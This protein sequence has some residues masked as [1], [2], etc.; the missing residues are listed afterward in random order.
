MRFTPPATLSWRYCVSTVVPLIAMARSAPAP[1]VTLEAVTSTPLVIGWTLP[2]APGVSASVPPLVFIEPG[3]K[4]MLPPVV[5]AKFVADGLVIAALTVSVPLPLSPICSV[6]AVVMRSSSAS[7]KASV[8]FVVSTVDPMSINAPAPAF[9]V[10]PAVPEIEPV[11]SEMLVF[12]PTPPA[13]VIV[14]L[15]EIGPVLL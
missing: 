8:L 3:L 4:T 10:T 14:P 13:S 1:K 11:A 12:A 9:N 5:S 15:V 7:D 2:L 6:P